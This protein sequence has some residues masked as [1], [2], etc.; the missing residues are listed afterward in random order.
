MKNTSF[1]GNI[2]LL[3]RN[4]LRHDVTSRLLTAIFR[5]ELP[6]GTRLVAQTLA[7]QFGISATPVRES[8]LEM[9]AVGMVEFPHNRGA[10]VKPWGRR[11][12]REV[13]HLRRILETEAARTACGKIDP[14]E[15]KKLERESRELLERKSE[16]GYGEE[17]MAI[18]RKLHFLILEACENE[19]LMNEVQRYDVLIQAI[20]EAVANEQ[21]AQTQA[22]RDH[23]AIIEGL[24]AGH[25]ETAA[26]CMAD[27]IDNTAKAIEK[28]MF[29]EVSQPDS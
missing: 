26:A 29:G 25:S 1:I 27:H 19:R 18:D 12:L 2:A 9:E 24:T 22:I 28:V 23:L 8:L 7:K 3:S 6:E 11:Q 4:A 14:E 21:E 5:G 16:A 15:L 10:V 13:Y 20:R 17:A